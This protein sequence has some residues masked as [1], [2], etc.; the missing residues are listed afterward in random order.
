MRTIAIGIVASLAAVAFAG[1]VVHAQLGSEQ[2]PVPSPTPIIT[3][4]PS[5]TDMPT[6]TVVPITIEPTATPTPRESFC[7][8]HS[9]PD[10]SQCYADCSTKYIVPDPCNE[11]T[12]SCTVKNQQ[13]TICMSD[14][15]N[16][17]QG[18]LNDCYKQNNITPTP[19]ALHAASN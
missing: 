16:K 10:L 3:N 1:I 17:N 15:G 11:A 13:K 5:P 8:S 19:Q 12:D 4:I 9:A 18:E 14:C 2:A 7:S 6:P